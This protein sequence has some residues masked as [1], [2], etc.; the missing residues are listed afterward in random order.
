M[1]YIP[2]EQFKRAWIFNHHEM[3]VSQSDREQIKPLSESYAADVW[4]RLVS[5]HCDH[6][7]HF[8]TEDWAQAD[9]TWLQEGEWQSQWESD[10]TELPDVIADFINWDSNT[11]VYFCYDS[12]LIVETTWAVFQRTWKNFLFFDDGPLLIGKKRREVMQFIDEGRLR[13]G[14]K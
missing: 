3:P 7:D 8:G 11:V 1:K 9:S 14:E 6:P 10:E 5:E 12:S 4:R 13:V 2:L